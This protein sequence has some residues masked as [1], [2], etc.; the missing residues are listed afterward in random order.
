[1]G[2]HLPF[3]SPP[4][5]SL[6]PIPLPRYSPTSIKGLALCG[7][8]S[9]LLA[10]G[11][12]E[13]APPSPGFYGRLFVVWKT[14]GSWRPVIDLSRL[15]EFVL[16]THFK[17]ESSQSVLSSIQ[18]T[19]WM[20]S[21]DLKDAYLQVAVHPDSRQFLRCVVDREVYQFRALCFGLS[22]APQVFRVMAPVSVMLHAMGD[23]DN[24]LILASSRSEA[25]WA[26]DEVLS[27]CNRLVIIIKK[28]KSCLQPTLTSTYL[29]MVIVSPSF[30][31][32]PSQKMV[33]TLLTQI[34]EFLSFRQQNVVSW[35]CLLGHL[36][37]FCHLI[38]GCCLR[39][40]SLQLLLR[41]CCVFVD[42]SVYLYWT[43][44]IESDLIWWF[45]T[46]LLAGIS[47]VSPQPNGLEG[48]TCST[49]LSW[50]A[51][52]TWSGASPSTCMNSGP[53]TSAFSTLVFF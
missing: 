42:E 7:E 22:T 35:W 46:H 5:L 52:R 24:W 14:L 10:E 40:R 41:D 12:I 33:S 16:Q 3:S 2:Y 43:P 20:V 30:R 49:N 26:R 37:S 13:L 29:G 19:D 38:P 28:T 32:L 17:M 44:E 51:G 31:A 36:S 45:D 23:L 48:Q 39:M 21:I 6:A 34:T 4:P 15:N 50:V 1:M 25:L 9:A 27:L 8:V 18:R 47:L 11:V 53:F